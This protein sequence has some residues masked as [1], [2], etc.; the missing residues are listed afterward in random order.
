MENKQLDTGFRSTTG[1]VLPALKHL[2]T[3]FDSAAQLLSGS[4]HT[5]TSDIS[6]KK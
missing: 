1:S 5:F 6:D 4:R 2:R 3:P